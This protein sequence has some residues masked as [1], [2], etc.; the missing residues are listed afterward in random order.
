MNYDNPLHSDEGLKLETSV[1]EYFTLAN[2]PDV[3]VDNLLQCFTFP[4]TQHT[5]STS[6]NF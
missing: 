4:P 5:I 1:F 2:S 6:L 3:V